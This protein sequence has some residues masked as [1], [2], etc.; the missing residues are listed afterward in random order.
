VVLLAGP[1]EEQ[2]VE[3]IAGRMTNPCVISTCDIVSLSVLKVLIKRMAL[4]VTN[5]TGPRHF[6]SA[7]GVPSVVLIGSTNPDWTENNDKRQVVLQ[8]VPVCGPCHLKSCPYNHQC[9]RLIKP[10]V[11][12]EASEKLLEAVS[13]G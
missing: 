5:D 10:S 4:L 6:A 9:M 7:Y 11:V 12:I 13:H 8:R 1:N 2:I 3:N